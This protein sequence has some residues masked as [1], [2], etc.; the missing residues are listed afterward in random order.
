MLDS[1]LYLIFEVIE[2]ADNCNQAKGKFSKF[3]LK[4]SS[5]KHLEDNSHAQMVSLMNKLLTSSRGSDDLFVGFARDCR[6]RQQEL[7]NEKIIKDK[8]HFR[9]MMKDIFGF[10]EHQ[11]KVTYGLGYILTQARNKDEA[12]IDKAVGIAD[13]RF[14][15]DLIHCYVGQYI[16]GIQQKGVLSKQIQSK[17][18]TELESFE[19]TVFMKK[20]LIRIY[21]TSSWVVKSQQSMNAPIWIIIGFQ[22][23][24]RQNSKI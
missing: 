5:G 16:P 13:S 22:Q 19:R 4:T 1:Y 20:Y 21:G 7:T 18:P 14:K 11:E 24:E 15:I 2:T 6:R 9:N 3:I 12:V 10:V 17:R 23:R 8:Y